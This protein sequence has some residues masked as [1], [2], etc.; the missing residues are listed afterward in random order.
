MK[1]GTT[2]P[3]KGVTFTLYT[4]SDTA[5]DHI[6]TPVA[7]RTTTNSSDEYTDAVF[8]GLLEG[9][10][11]LVETSQPAGYTGAGPGT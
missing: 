2:S 1:D 3:L 6:G 11:I 9:S 7:T 8:S 5:T 10:Y 4:Y